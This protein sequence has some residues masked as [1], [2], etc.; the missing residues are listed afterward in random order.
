MAPN[1]AAARSLH[2]SEDPH[3]ALA[4]QVRDMKEAVV[5]NNGKVEQ[6]SRRQPRVTVPARWTEL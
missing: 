4:K 5:L 2:R 6:V 1:D 3:D